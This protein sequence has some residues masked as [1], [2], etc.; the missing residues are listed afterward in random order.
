LSRSL[1]DI[2]NGADLRGIVRL[3]EEARQRSARG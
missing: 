1:E 2:V 3:V